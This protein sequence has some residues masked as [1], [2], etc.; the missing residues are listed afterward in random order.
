MFP[1]TE[2]NRNKVNNV[3]N[4]NVFDNNFLDLQPWEEDHKDIL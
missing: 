1:Q 4:I 2:R 3:R